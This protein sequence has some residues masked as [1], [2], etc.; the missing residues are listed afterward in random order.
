MVSR[1]SN[2][3]NEVLAQQFPDRDEFQLNTASYCFEFLKLEED[4]PA[5]PGEQARMVVM[6]LFKRAVPLIRYDTEDEVLWQS[7][8]TSGWI[9]ETLSE[10]E[11]RRSDC[12]C[13]TQDRLLS[14]AVVNLH[15]SSFTQLKQYPFIQEAKGQ[16]QI[17]LNGAQA[18][19]EDLEFIDLGK[20]FLGLDASISWVHMDQIPLLDS[21][22][23]KSVLS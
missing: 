9:A 12:I 7:S 22:K 8:A 13:D 14:P 15:F 19:Y 23:F 10:I 1:Y 20:G 21:G 11:G 6:D 2:Q 17:V 4:K 18:H 3:E 5:G 16:Y